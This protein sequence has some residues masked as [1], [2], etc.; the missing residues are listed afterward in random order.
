MSH[1]RGQATVELAL[2]LPLVCLVLLGVV[3]LAVVVRD[4]LAVQLA[5]REAARAAA[6]SADAGGAGAA[7]GRAAVRLAPLDVQVA[8]SGNSVTATAVYVEH[9]D[10]PLIGLLL[11]DVRVTATAT[12][13]LEPP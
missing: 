8:V 10:V 9:T 6:V 11:P 5:A 3:Q 2:G 4:Q 12:M 13:R 1:D 7:A